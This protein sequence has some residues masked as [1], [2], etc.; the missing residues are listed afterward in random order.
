V[1]RALALLCLLSTAA[2]ADEDGMRCGHRLVSLG[3][4]ESAVQTKCGPPS[5]ARRIIARG[6]RRAGATEMVI[7]LW[8]YDLGAQTFVRQLRFEDGSLRRIDVD[9]YGR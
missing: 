3:E 7:D 1:R 2:G 8:T 9:G 5:A 4:G 6:R